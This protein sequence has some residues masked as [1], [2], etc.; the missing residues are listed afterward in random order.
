MDEPPMAH[1]CLSAVAIPWRAF[2]SAP[3]LHEVA[4]R[5]A[6]VALQ[7]FAVRLPG[8]FGAKLLPGAVLS[9]FLRVTALPA[10][11]FDGYLLPD[12][13]RKPDRI[14]TIR[15]KTRQLHL[16]QSK[17]S[18]SPFMKCN[19]ALF[20]YS[21]LSHS[22]SPLICS[23]T[24]NDNILYIIIKIIGYYQDGAITH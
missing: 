13:G 6:A 16:P 10:L 4:L 9:P 14:S 7:P 19:V 22:M 8:Q 15:G 11:P 3:Q 12:D 1:H 2:G 18:L 5:P 21:K 24:N 20:E 17:A 23:S